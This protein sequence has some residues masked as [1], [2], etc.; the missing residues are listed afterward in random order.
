MSIKN[1]QPTY[2]SNLLTFADYDS[3]KQKFGKADVKETESAGQKITYTTLPILYSFPKRDDKLRI[4]GP[5]C[6]LPM[7]VL[8]NTKKKT[9]TVEKEVRGRKKEVTEEYEAE[10]A[11]ILISFETYDD[12]SIDEKTSKT[13]KE[14]LD[15]FVDKKKGFFARVE[16]KNSDY[17]F[18]NPG[19]LPRKKQ[20]YDDVN[21][22]YKDALKRVPDYPRKK[23][24]TTGVKDVVFTDKPYCKW[25]KLI[26][27]TSK[28][29][30]K[31]RS[32][33]YLPHRDSRG[34]F[35][36]V[37]FEDLNRVRVYGIPTFEVSSIYIGTDWST[38][39]KVISFAIT[40]LEAIEQV[41]IQERT[42]E[43]L[44]SCNYDSVCESIQILEKIR[45]RKTLEPSKESIKTDA[46]SNQPS[47]DASD[48]DASDDEGE[49]S[50][51]IQERIRAQ[52][53][54]QK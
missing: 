53:L 13:K 50:M 25:F 3:N 18:D 48:D 40:K 9:R 39:Y 52:Q 10:E 43:N 36:E 21:D 2:E 26:C 29:G 5:E 54:K 11:S 4:E 19:F 51:T 17:L 15:D 14:L 41:N 32:K 8:L 1:K 7:G 42:L 16:M 23:S 38:Q 33:F 28:N 45:L 37:S 20:D 35:M 31:F 34:K 44:S 30:S 46:N 6:C 47:D 27:G 24:H 12:M 22:I 49:G